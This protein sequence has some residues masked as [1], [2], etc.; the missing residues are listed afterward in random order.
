MKLKFL[1]LLAGLSIA[2]CSRS[3]AP[4]TAVRNPFTEPNG[5]AAVLNEKATRY[6]T[7]VDDRQ[8]TLAANTPDEYVP[9]G[10]SA[11]GRK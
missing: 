3:D 4:E 8:L 9:N 11:S 7:S 6:F 5:S 2:A 10:S 1:L